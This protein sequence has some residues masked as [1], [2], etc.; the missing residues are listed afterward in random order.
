MARLELEGG[1]AC[2]QAAEACQ[3][4]LVGLAVPQHLARSE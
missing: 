3:P 4:P 1:A 2:E